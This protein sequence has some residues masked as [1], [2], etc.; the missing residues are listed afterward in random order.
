M[1]FRRFVFSEIFGFRI[2]YQ[3]LYEEDGSA[4]CVDVNECT[5]GNHMCSP[6]AQCINQEG[7]HI[8]QCRPGFSGDG[9]NCE[10]EL[11]AY[12]RDRSYRTPITS[13]VAV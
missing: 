1:L 11:A 9:R 3:Y 7:S 6:D 8:C 12:Q 5:A 10:S 4:I 13:T 2:S